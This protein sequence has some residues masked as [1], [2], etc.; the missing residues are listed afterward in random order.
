MKKSLIAVAG[1]AVLS[2]SAYASKARMAAL[3]QE[4]DGSFYI[5]D[6]R[7]TFYNPAHYNMYNN[8]AIFEWGNDESDLTSATSRGTS[9]AEGG[10]ARQAG[11]FIYGVYVGDDTGNQRNTDSVAAGLNDE[12]LMDNNRVTLSFAGDAGIK[13]G[14]SLWYSKQSEQL[15]T[16]PSNTKELEGDTLG[17]RGGVAGSNWQAYA[18]LDLKD[19]ATGSQAAG[20]LVDEKDTYEADTGI[21]LGGT[22]SMNAWTFGAEYETSGFEVSENSN[23]PK[24]GT[25]EVKQLELSLVLVTLRRWAT[26]LHSSGMLTG[27][28][29][30][31]KV[32]T[33]DRLL[34]TRTK[35]GILT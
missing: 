23:D 5:N 10:F 35:V 15:G 17:L 28:A 29:Q 6:Q 16:T 12:F 14:A 2:T 11:N 4:D 18:I 22:Y 21:L 32:K 13:W 33:L 27:K 8:F 24:N 34:L 7:N 20:T 19:E 30:L 9:N 3:G 26:K 25:G 1:L 31:Q